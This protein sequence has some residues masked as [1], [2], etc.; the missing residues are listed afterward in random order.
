MDA[1]HLLQAYGFLWS[2]LTFAALS[3][4]AIL[5]IWLA[6]MPKRTR[7]EMRERLD[8]YI[9]RED[10]MEGQER[11]LAVRKFAPAARGVLRRVGRL[12]PG[13]DAERTRQTLE[14]AGY[15]LGLGVLDFYGLRILL[16]LLFGGGYFLL[17]GRSQSAMIALRNTAV[18]LLV[19]YMLPNLW[20]NSRAKSRKHKMLLA[21]P[22]MLDMLTIGVEAG[23]GFESAMVRVS[24]KWDNPLTQEFRR[25]VGEMRI[26]LGRNEA[27]NRMAQR[28]GLEDVKSFVSVLVQSSTLGVSIAQVLHSQAADVRTKRRVRA[29]ELARKAGT[30]M[31]IPLVFLIFPTMFVVILGP[32]VPVLMETFSGMK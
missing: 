21:F 32:A 22:D 27:L 23:L 4:L 31:M 14:Q 20:L 8:G 30:K 1:G 12:L 6:L 25:A 17:F 9:E 26:G 2:P 16:P 19:A 7:R 24:A 15:P 18:L 11:P 13:G 28:V 10:A 3:A 5:L 29:E